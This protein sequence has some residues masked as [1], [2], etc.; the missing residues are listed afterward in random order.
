MR[1]LRWYSLV[2]FL[3]A[4]DGLL[5]QA[6]WTD[7]SNDPVLERGTDGSWDSGGVGC[8]TVLALD[9]LCAGGGVDATYAMWYTG[10]IA[11]TLAAS[12]VGMA[13]SNDLLA[14]SK[15]AAPVFT[16]ELPWEGTVL[17]CASVLYDAESCT[18]KMWYQNDADPNCRIGLATSQDGLLWER[19]QDEPVL[20]GDPAPSWERLCAD[21]PTVLLINGEYK[22]WYWAGDF[23]FATPGLIGHATSPDGVLWI[24]HPQPVLVP[25]GYSHAGTPDV[26]YHEASRS[27]EMWYSLLSGNNSV[28][29]GYATS[30]DGI[31]WTQRPESFRDRTSERLGEPD[32]HFNGTTY[33]MF[34]TS[35]VGGVG[36][37]RLVTSPWTLPRASFDASVAEGTVPFAVA[38]NA[39][40]SVSPAEGGIT[41]YAWDFGDGESAE[42]LQAQ[43]E[44]TRPGEFRITLSVTDAAGN[45]GRVARPVRA[46]PHSGPVDPWTAADI[47]AVTF[48]GGSRLDEGCLEVSEPAGDIGGTSDRI[49]FVYQK[50]TGDVRFEAD[51]ADWT[52]SSTSE[53]ALMLR[54]GLEPGERALAIGVRQSQVVRYQRLTKPGGTSS[55]NVG[56]HE[57]AVRLRVERRGEEFRRFFSLNGG[58][59]WSAAESVTPD[60][61]FPAE[62]YAGVAAAGKTLNALARVRLCDLDLTPG[63]PET[64]FLR[65]EANGQGGRD[66]SDGVFIL[67]YL[68]QGGDPPVCLKA[69]D[70]NDD[71]GVDLSDAVHLLAYLFTG[72]SAPAAPAE[73]CGLD[74]TPDLLPCDAFTACP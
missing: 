3:L 12:S 23:N 35:F 67:Q 15:S 55:L 63:T 40:N 34:Y 47:G 14:W 22:M 4:A 30:M 68:F 66:L 49:R 37:I 56:T 19:F 7:A 72:G 13:I 48:P 18:F 43:H 8:V 33:F 65:G 44:Y 62:I 5:A 50:V 17:G 21:H 29:I 39:A 1:G 24:K 64:L 51:V 16:S 28:A 25:V 38:V 53:L 52:P 69:A 26:L 42:G 61:A 71:G 60:P 45:V 59:T 27:Y 58:A 32:V 46:L 20:A 2:L 54:A 74:L 10:S 31:T 9:N 6:L 41:N 11:S 57:G 70:S 73:G 36:S